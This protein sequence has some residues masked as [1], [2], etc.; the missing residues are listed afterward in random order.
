MKITLST[1]DNDIYGEG[2]KQRQGTVE[3]RELTREIGI[4]ERVHSTKIVVVITLNITK[5]VFI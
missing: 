4:F 2:K 1:S 3:K 5:Y